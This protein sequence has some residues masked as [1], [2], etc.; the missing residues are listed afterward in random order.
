L[1]VDARVNRLSRDQI[2]ITEAPRNDRPNDRFRCGMLCDGGGMAT[3]L[4]GP[5]PNGTCGSD[6][7]PCEPIRTFRGWRRRAIAGFTLVGLASL[8][9]W[10]AIDYR[11]F[12]KPGDLSH[13]HAV[14]FKEQSG[15]NQCT[16]CH[17]NANVSLANWF[18]SENILKNRLAQTDSCVACHHVKMPADVARLP[19]NLSIERLLEIRAAWNDAQAISDD[20]DRDTYQSVS[21]RWDGGLAGDLTKSVD[22]IQCASCHREHGGSHAIMTTMSNAQ[23][24]TCHSRTFESFRNGHPDWNAW[25]HV[26]AK[27]IAFD[28]TTHQRLHFPKSRPQSSLGD[29]AESSISASDRGGDPSI[30]PGRS[31]DCRLCHPGV[32]VTDHDA[33]GLAGFT[34]KSDSEP[35]RTVSFEIGCSDCHANGI[36]QQATERL[37]LFALPTLPG[38]AAAQVGD[39][40]EEA[41]GFFD[42]EIGGLAGWLI[43][44]ES[45]A[46]DAL[47]RLPG[48]RSISQVDP[49]KNDQVEA[50]VIAATAVRD[51]MDRFATQGSNVLTSNKNQR[52]AEAMRQI[53]R[54]VPPQLV[55]DARARW[56]VS[57]RTTDGSAGKT[58]D[59]RLPVLARPLFDIPAASSDDPLLGDPLLDDPLLG[60][61]LLGDPLLD[62]PLLEGGEV[63][64]P[65]SNTSLSKR[66]DPAA[67]LPDG[68]W[69]R[70]DLRYAISYRGKGHADPVLKAAVEMAASLQENDPAR[71]SL[72]AQSAVAS[73]VVCHIGAMHAQGPIW[74]TPP[75]RLPPKAL[76]K[77][78]H[79]PHFNL[80]QLADCTHCHMTHTDAE[81][82]NALVKQKSAPGYDPTV[83]HGFISIGKSACITCH[84]QG[85]AGDHCTQCHRYHS[86]P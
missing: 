34:G 77:F 8:L 24:Q 79:R 14:I 58:S 62:D 3:C 35:L 86:P 66:F 56:F 81:T 78:S 18:G 72:L 55:A 2:K 7:E 85:A 65:V 44:K 82:I 75:G 83:D 21:H 23:C 10:L 49:G 43:R 76:T 20:G 32:S 67:L 39:W 52:E 70:D 74:K 36:R 38:P 30:E 26:G 15:V 60:D 13:S 45:S 12:L 41:T 57:G 27:V 61:P 37:D 50:A 54:T 68:G 31:F 59:A 9:A 6:N 40:P 19:H 28:H 53:L 5:R 22:S 42:G 71:M 51:A 47:A 73:C 48:G 17:P 33:I 25:P 16:A 29:G 1:A 84:T 80:P 64:R 4:R 69:Y 63:D 11:G 46:A